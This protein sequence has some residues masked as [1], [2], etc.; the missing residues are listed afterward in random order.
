MPICSGKI[1]DF[2]L[3]FWVVA[4][5]GGCDSYE[6]DPPEVRRVDRF[7]AWS[8]DG[9][10]IAYLHDAGPTEDTIDVTGLY[11]LDLETDSTW[12]VTEGRVMSPDWHPDGNIIAF[13]TGNI[14][15]I[16]SGGSGLKRITDNGSAFFPSWS[17]SGKRLAYDATSIPKTGIWLVDPDGN[18]RKN[19]GLGRYPDWSAQGERLV[20]EGPPGTAESGP[21][22]WISDTSATDS[23]QFTDNESSTTAIPLGARTESGL[24]GL[25][26]TRTDT[27]SSG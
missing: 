15:T 24:L 20:Y 21:Q 8:P 7:P 11:V 22:L 2:L 18:T 14:F 4:M 19:L 25:P 9:R 12:L 10:F 13:S 17:P 23:T 26:S 5:L 6:P 3:V 1:R 16:R 27:L